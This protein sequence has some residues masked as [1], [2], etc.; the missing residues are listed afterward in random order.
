MLIRLFSVEIFQCTM[1][2]L[3]DDLETFRTK[4]KIEQLIDDFAEQNLLLVTVTANR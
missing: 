2:L 3:F 4:F 1:H